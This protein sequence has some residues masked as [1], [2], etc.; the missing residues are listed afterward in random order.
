M[1]ANSWPTPSPHKQIDKRLRLLDLTPPVAEAFTAG[2]TGIEHA[3][4]IAKLAA[5][6]QE[7]A[8]THCFDCFYVAND[9]DCSLVP[10]GQLQAWIEHNVYLSLKSVPFSKDDE[11]LVPEAGSCANCPKRT[12]FNTLLFS[13]VR[14]DSDS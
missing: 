3:L 1:S 6:L 13:E 14:E 12:G 11:T 7:K 8:F 2:H 4:L 10:A 5:D 9:S